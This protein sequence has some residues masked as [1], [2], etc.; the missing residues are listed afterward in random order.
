LFKIPLAIETVAI[1]IIDLGT[2]LAP[3]IALAYEEPEDSIM[4][5]PPRTK[6]EHLISWRVMLVC[7][8]TIGMIETIVGYFSFCWVFNDHG[9]PLSS[10]T[11]MGL[12]Y[13]YKYEDLD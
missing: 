5:N 7:Y 1:L 4:T 8:L 2:D 10:L 9:F 13:T 6:D 3:T 11:G 12:Q